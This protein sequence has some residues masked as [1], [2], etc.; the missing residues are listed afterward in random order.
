MPFVKP[1]EI[2]VSIDVGCHQ[3][4]IAIGLSTGELLD[5]FDIEHKSSGF[6]SFF[7]RIE[8]WEKQ[9]KA[10]VSVA[11]EG[12]N[13]YARPLDR[14]IRVRNYR[15]YNINNLKLAR[16]KE[17]FPGAA[18]T[19]PIDARKGLELFQLS[20]Q[21]PLAKGVLQEIAS[22]PK[23]NEHLKRMTRRRRR[24]V[25]E[26]VSIINALQSDL[27]AVSP[28]IT[29][30]TKDV[31]NMWFLSFLSASPDL[32]KLARK[33][34]SSL[35]KIRGVGKKYANKIEQWQQQALFSDEIDIVS[36]M[37]YED[38]MRII[39]LNEKIKQ[40]NAHIEQLNDRSEISTLLRSI[41]GFGATS[42]AEIAGE[43]G[44]I[45]RFAGES[46]LALYLG[47]AAL[48]NSSGSHKGSKK[49]KHVN[50]RAKAALMVAIDRHRKLVP[51]SQRYYDKKRNKGK[52]HNQAIRSLGRHLTRVIYKMLLNGNIY[53]VKKT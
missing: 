25:N 30:I 14:L 37:I 22:I 43:I 12:Y 42:C 17:I 53:E 51:E 19:D 47:M 6:K 31:N 48:D 29:E 27:Q 20:D 49:P 34:R 46:S 45:E 36:P 15:L 9:Y 5:E 35:L 28:G 11:M 33:R 2:R 23:E 13:G 4:S 10:P 7:K 32:R 26:R 21:L 8:H 38:T 40:L 39:E 3:H 16:F 41:P 52:K 1:Q 50:T 24:L 18:K 44:T